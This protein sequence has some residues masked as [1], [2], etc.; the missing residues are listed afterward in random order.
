MDAGKPGMTWRWLF[1]LHAGLADD[2]RPLG[3]LGGDVG[4]VFVRA[5][6]SGS[7]PSTASRRLHLALASAALSAALSFSTIGRGVP[8]G[9][10][11]P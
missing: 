5:D 9:A 7:A 6:G 2:L 10:T 4:G 3:L 11:M 8:A 1:P